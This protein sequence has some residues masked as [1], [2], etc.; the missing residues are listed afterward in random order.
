MRWSIIRPIKATHKP[1]TN[2]LP[3]SHTLCWDLNQTKMVLFSLFMV[4]IAAFIGTQDLGQEIMIA[5]AES[6][7]GKGLVLGLCVAFIGLIID[8]L[9]NKWAL[10]KKVKLGLVS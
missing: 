3:T 5:L 7:V 4:I 8:H 10:D 9:I 6:D 2:P 1:K